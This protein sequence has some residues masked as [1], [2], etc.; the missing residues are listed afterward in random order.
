MAATDPRTTIFDVINTYLAANPIMKDDDMTNA[1]VGV[2][3]ESGPE[4]LKYLFEDAGFDVVITLGNPSSDSTRPIQDNPVHYVMKH[5]VTATTIDKYA[6]GVLLCTAARM[7]Y[8]ATWML[9]NAI[10]G[11]AQSAAGATPAY[12]MKITSERSTHKLL[13]GLDIWETPHIVEYVTGGP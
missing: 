3:W 7:Q 13:A 9:R 6:A 2:L 11:S 5:P 1:S 4:R 8:K 10:E 12:T